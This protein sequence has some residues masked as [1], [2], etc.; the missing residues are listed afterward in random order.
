M[1]LTSLVLAGR[2]LVHSHGLFPVPQLISIPG[3][4]CF[5]WFGLQYARVRKIP[6]SG[7]HKIRDYKIQKGEQPPES[8]APPG[9][10]PCACTLSSG[11]RQA[12]GSS[13]P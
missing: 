8:N 2:F 4:S 3:V 6:V 12:Q 10:L 7:D 13:V 11:W 5:S 9:S 1:S